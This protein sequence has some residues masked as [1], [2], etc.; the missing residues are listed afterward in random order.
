MEQATQKQIKFAENLGIEAPEKYDKAALRGLIDVKL[1]ERDGFKPKEQEKT[2]PEAPKS[3]KT[4][5]LTPEQVRFNALDIALRRSPT[6]LD[7]EKLI[8]E[9]EKFRKY[10][11][12][13]G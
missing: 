13:S 5:H 4:Y 9:A 10:M 3:E 1:K 2:Q 7:A 8:E 11:E 12:K 6:T